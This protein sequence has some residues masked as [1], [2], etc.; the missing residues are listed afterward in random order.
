MLWPASVRTR[1]LVLSGC[2]LWRKIAL[3]NVWLATLL[4]FPADALKPICASQV[5]C[6]GVRKHPLRRALLIIKAVT[7]SGCTHALEL[8]EGLQCR[9]GD[10]P[11]TLRKSILPCRGSSISNFGKKRNSSCVL[12]EGVQ[13]KELL[14]DKYIGSCIFII[15]NAGYF[16]RDSSGLKGILW[17]LVISQEWHVLS[18]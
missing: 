5:F 9:G 3:S 14:S 4:S 13:I 17:F 18:F 16:C 7:F 6:S 8:R 12:Q 11:C 10:A 2:S 15:L 1:P